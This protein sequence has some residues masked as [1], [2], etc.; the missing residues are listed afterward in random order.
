MIIPR[1]PSTETQPLATSS[2]ADTNL[3]NLSEDE[4]RRLARERLRDLQVSH[5]PR[6]ELLPCHKIRPDSVYSYHV[7]NLCARSRMSPDTS[8]GRLNLYHQWSG[9]SRWSNWMMGQRPLISP[10]TIEVKHEVLGLFTC[11]IWQWRM[12]Y[13]LNV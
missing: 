2:P 8:R 6:R 9:L 13:G 12:E 11:V 3:S 4:I 7:T 5:C 1:S 10:R